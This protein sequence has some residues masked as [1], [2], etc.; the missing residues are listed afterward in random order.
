MRDA[1]LRTDAG[2]SRP[3]LSQRNN[4]LD[5]AGYLIAALMLRSHTRNELAEITGANLNTLDRWLSALHNAGVVRISGYDER[6]GRG[7]R[8]RLW[9]LQSRPFGL[10]D[11][12]PRKVA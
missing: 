12:A 4:F 8:A 1:Y 10:D 9:E 3:N 11:V 5:H 2:I 6:T 7:T